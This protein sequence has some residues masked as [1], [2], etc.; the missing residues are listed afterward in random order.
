MYGFME[1]SADDTAQMISVEAAG[2]AFATAVATARY[3]AGVSRQTA[4]TIFAA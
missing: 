1:G 2:T 4:A 3:C